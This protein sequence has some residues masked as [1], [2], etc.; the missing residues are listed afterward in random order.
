MDYEDAFR[1]F[2]KHLPPELQALDA[3][4][5]GVLVALIELAQRTRIKP[6]A[7]IAM[8]QRIVLALQAVERQVEAERSSAAV[9]ERLLREVGGKS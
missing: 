7:L 3:C 4:E 9:A 8:L 2:L 6:S 5:C 1:N